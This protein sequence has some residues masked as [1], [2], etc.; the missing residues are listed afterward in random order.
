MGFQPGVRLQLEGADVATRFVSSSEIEGTVRQET[1]MH[2]QRVRLRNPD[3]TTTTYSSFMRSVPLG[4]SSR[5]LL[6]QTVPVFSQATFVEAYFNPN[7]G[8]D[9]FEALAFQTPGSD[10]ADI[11]IEGYSADGELLASTN[12]SL[13][14]GMRISRGVSEFLPGVTFAAGSYLRVFSQTPVQML[15]LIGDETAGTVLPLDPSP[16]PP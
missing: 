11:A 14:A 3:R 5:P 13:P 10:S 1:R 15:G 6:A 4:E 16:A 7:T 2:G 8:A 12:V 9:L